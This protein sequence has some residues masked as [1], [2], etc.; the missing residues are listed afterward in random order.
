MQNFVIFVKIYLKIKMLKKKITKGRDH[1][2]YTANKDVLPIASVKL[3]VNSDNY[4][5]N[6]TEVFC[7]YAVSE[8]FVIFAGK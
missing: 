4:R 3:R 2:H 6:L 1:C 7:K 8:K 5:S